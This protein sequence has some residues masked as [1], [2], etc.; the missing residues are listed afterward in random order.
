MAQLNGECLSLA[1]A[2]LSDNAYMGLAGNVS[3]ADVVVGDKDYTSLGYANAYT[4]L[5]E[6]SV[7]TASQ[8]SQRQFVTAGAEALSV[9]SLNR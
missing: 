5:G 1:D 2:V 8:L 3:V 4:S 7:G 6:V 9:R